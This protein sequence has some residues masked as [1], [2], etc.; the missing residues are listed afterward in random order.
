MAELWLQVE[1]KNP[2]D[3]AKLQ[4][5]QKNLNDLES[6]AYYE[7]Q[8]RSNPRDAAVH[9]AIGKVLGPMGRLNEAVQHFQTAVGLQPDL[10]E[11]HYYLGLS[12]LT[13]QDP[14][15]AA[16]E[17]E[18]ALHYDPRYA[19]AYD[20][21]GLVALRTNRP[22]EAAKNFRRALELNPDDPAAR[23]NL[24]K[25]GVKYGAE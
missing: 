19:K 2:A 20:G 10:V 8:L 7:G 23:S 14:E 24:Q 22:E 1:V 21:L 25:L 12:A 5:V 17:F 15:Q 16:R 6:V 9:L 13:A 11:A 18:T 4:K 3:L